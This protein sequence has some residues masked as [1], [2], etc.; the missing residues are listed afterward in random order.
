MTLVSSR[1]T[2][3]ERPTGR[4]ACGALLAL[5]ACHSSSSA[6]PA[7][8]GVD[9]QVLSLS[10]WLGQLDPVETTDDAGASH[11]YGGLAALS[12]YF[13]T[14]RATHPSTLLLVGP[15]SFA[16]TPPLS[17]QF[18]DV[19]TV[20]AL[21]FLGATCD[22]LSNHNFDDGIPYLQKLVEASA[23]PYVS[24]NLNGV[25][26]AVSA[27]VR[28]PYLLAH[29]GGTTI[30]VLGIT[31]PDAPNHTTPGNFGTITISEPVSA[32]NAAAAS[33]RAAGAASVV[34]VTDLETDTID[35]AGVHSGPLIDFAAGLRGVDVVIGSIAANPGTPKVG[36]VLV[37]E[38]VWKG[39]TYG[40]TQLHVA[41]NGAVSASATVV[42]PDVSEVTPDP[43]AEALLAPYRAQLTTLFD[44]SISV[45]AAV[46]P[47]DDTEREEENALGD[48]VADSFVAK[49]ASEG[50]QLAIINAAGLRDS[51]PSSYAPAAAS[52]RRP[53]SGYAA[54]PPY[55]V[56]IGDPY[57]ILPFGNMCV[58]RTI[59]GATL[60]SMLEQSV[61]DEPS[62]F[63]GFL[64]ISGFKFVYQL[65]APPGTRVQSVTLDDGTSVARDDSRTWTFVDT[66]YLDSGGDGY[67]MLI[68]TPAIPGRDV[69]AEVFLDYLETN[70]PLAPGLSGRITQQP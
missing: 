70:A 42:V 2:R 41:T 67:G 28:V 55:D 38:H 27:S 46:F 53:A 62:P 11:Q 16:A 44:S 56:V 1:P 59:T 47:L 23:Y 24:S 58:V 63:T 17:S 43:N 21:A 10:S 8:D 45:A 37:V 12:S 68:E 39:M 65:S 64:Q 22:T 48:L 5:S 3:S 69:A 14:D 35:D 19:P 54:G 50:A 4:V 18:Q 51:L 61:Y 26:S 20:K 60:W 33:A 7:A 25:E 15:D 9:V 32:A 52:L 6:P 36:D 34:V 66:D 30:G 31:R 40:R 49:Y 13:A 57:T 29:A